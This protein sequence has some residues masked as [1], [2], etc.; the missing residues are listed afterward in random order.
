MA[1][2]RMFM[3]IQM[4]RRTDGRTDGQRYAIICPFFFFLKNGHTHTVIVLSIF[5]QSVIKLWHAQDL[6]IQSKHKQLSK[7]HNSETKKPKA[8]VIIRETLS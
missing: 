1:C 2:T 8:I 5:S 4:D 7:G 6:Y 3:D